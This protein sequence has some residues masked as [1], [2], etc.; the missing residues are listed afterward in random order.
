[1]FKIS[2][3]DLRRVLRD[4]KLEGFEAKVPIQLIVNGEPKYVIEKIENIVSL[5][6]IHPA[7]RIKIKALENIARMGRTPA[8]IDVEEFKFEPPSG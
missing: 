3:G 6:D 7:M 4:E 1:M 2:F 8:K 5:S